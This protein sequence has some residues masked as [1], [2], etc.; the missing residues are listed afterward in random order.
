MGRLTGENIEQ[1]RDY[2]N[3]N[4]G[5]KRRNYLTLKD[6]GMTAKGR[7][8][9]EKAEDIDCFVVHRVKVGDYEREVNCLY[10]QG[11][12]VDDCP[13]CRAKMARAARI[14][15]PFYDNNS[16]EIK[17]FERPNSYYSKISG[18]CSRYAPI[19]NYE[20]EIVRNGEKGNTKTDYDI[21][22]GRNADDTT[23]DDILDEC[24]V[25]TL[26]KILGT[27]VLDKSADDMEYFIEHGEFPSEDNTDVPVR[28]RNSDRE[29][30]TEGRTSR[31]GRSGDR[32]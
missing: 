27:Y 1:F 15:I 2:S 18:Y 25:E 32:F 29:E 6:H 8:L 10:E 30:N 22:P 20:V 11:G 16:K 21:F 13:F 23:V 28:R 3:S 24:D 17:I 14:Y 12:A 7:I 5:G 4:G 31:R 9:C 19:V 26:P